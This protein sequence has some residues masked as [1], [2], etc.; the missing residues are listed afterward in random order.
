[1]DY[2]ILDSQMVPDKNTDDQLEQTKAS[3]RDSG[4]QQKMY[5]NQT[6]TLWA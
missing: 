5:S 4:N 3:P 1:M 6:P 2:N